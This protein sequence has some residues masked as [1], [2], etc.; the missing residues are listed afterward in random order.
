MTS[1]RYFRRLGGKRDVQINITR[2]WARLG[3]KTWP[4]TWS[5]RQ[6]RAIHF[7]FGYLSWRIK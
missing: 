2:Y 3:I 5:D 6:K 4:P 7:G 1:S